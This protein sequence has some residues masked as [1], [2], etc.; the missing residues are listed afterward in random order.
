MNDPEYGAEK[1]DERSIGSEGREHVQ[2]SLHFNFLSSHITL[3]GAV[4]IFRIF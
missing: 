4:Q 3:Y 1:A 2:T